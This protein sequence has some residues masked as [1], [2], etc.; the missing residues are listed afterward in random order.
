MI[1]FTGKDRGFFFPL[2]WNIVHKY[3]NL[4]IMPSERERDG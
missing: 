1:N 4:S 3:L 2:Q